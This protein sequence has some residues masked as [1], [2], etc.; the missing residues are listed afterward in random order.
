MKKKLIFL[1]FTSLLDVIM[2]I[3]FFFIIFSKIETDE[4]R[5]GLEEKQNQI[6]V[7]Q[8]QYQE[9]LESRERELQQNEDKAAEMLETAGSERENAGRLLSEAE[10]AIARSGENAEALAEFSENKNIKL[11][12]I[13]APDGSDWSI[14]VIVGDKSIREIRKAPVPEL[15]GSLEA[16]FAERNYSDS[17]TILIE[18][19]Y[20]ATEIGTNRAYKDIDRMLKQVRTDYPHCFYSETDRSVL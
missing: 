20:D 13:M 11:S 9:E 18:L 14:S 12:L 10:K 4:Y 7:Q 19:F 6:A 8:A 5:Q 15:T 2:I 16:V 3:L 1:D 17:D